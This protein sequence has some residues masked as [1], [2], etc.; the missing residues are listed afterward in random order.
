MTFR[1]EAPRTPPSKQAH[2]LGQAIERELDDL[3]R[4]VEVLVWRTG[5]AQGRDT[6]AAVADDVL[7]DV[8]VRALGRASAFD[9]SRSAHAWLFGFAVN[10]V[11][12][13]RR[14]RLSEEQRLV[15]LSDLDPDGEHFT[16]LGR[17]LCA[18][19]A[20]GAEESFAE[21]LG[22]AAPTDREVLRLTFAEQLRGPDLAAALGTSEGAARVRLSRALRRLATAYRAA[23]QA[24]AER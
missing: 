2:V 6:V 16:S 9:P 5:L 15:Q 22:L 21:L 8:V 1:D 13:R 12:E 17:N 10:V 19:S 11:R 18:L 24:G 7:Q 20:N 4:G 23:E 14:Q 3:R